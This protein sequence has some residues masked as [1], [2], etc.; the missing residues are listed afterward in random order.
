MGHDYGVTLTPYI[1]DA[2]ANITDYESLMEISPW[3]A[4][5]TDSSCTV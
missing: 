2:K 1:N 4:K 5:E 3:Q